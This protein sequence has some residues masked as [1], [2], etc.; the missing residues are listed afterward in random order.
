MSS[1]HLYWK[2]LKD[3]PLLSLTLLVPMHRYTTGC[4]S[5]SLMPFSLSLLSLTALSLSLPRCSSLYLFLYLTVSLSQYLHSVMT[6]T[7][8]EV[9]TS[10]QGQHAGRL[11]NVEMALEALYNVIHSN[12][13][14]EI[15][16]LGQFKLLFSLLRLQGANRLQTLAL[17][18]I[19]TVTGN[20]SCVSNIADSNVL[21]YLMLVLH[22]LPSC[23]HQL[24]CT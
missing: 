10:R 17:Q 1:Q 16:C 11:R 13:G 23:K 22:M 19:S 2:M 9:D 15:Q 4:R 18:V 7:A 3:L 8:S 21:Q 12:A 5:P 24:Y 6:L 14:V 20:K